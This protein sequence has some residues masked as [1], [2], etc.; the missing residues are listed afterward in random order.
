MHE[1]MAVEEMLLT[2]MPENLVNALK[3]QNVSIVFQLNCITILGFVARIDPNL[4]GVN[5]N[6]VSK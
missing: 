4:A 1:N 2:V 3:V 5:Q 6:S